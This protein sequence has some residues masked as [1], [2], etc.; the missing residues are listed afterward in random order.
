VQDESEGL[1]A[2]VR[3]ELMALADSAPGQESAA[4]RVARALGGRL[5]LAG[6]SPTAFDLVLPAR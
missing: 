4:E 6:Q 2:P 1:P 5:V 3:Q